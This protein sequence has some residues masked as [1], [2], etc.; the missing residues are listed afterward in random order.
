MS[1]VLIPK[2]TIDILRRLA[3]NV[4]R[5][6][7]L[8]I[9]A[10]E[11]KMWCTSGTLIGDIGSN[12]LPAHMAIINEV[13]QLNLGKN[14]AVVI[15]RC[16]E[17]NHELSNKQIHDLKEKSASGPR[18]HQHYHAW[19]VLDVKVEQSDIIDITGHHF[20]G[21]DVSEN[22]MNNQIAAREKIKHHAVLTDIESVYSYHANLVKAQLTAGTTQEKRKGLIAYLQ[23][24]AMLQG[25]SEEIALGEVGR[26]ALEQEN[27]ISTSDSQKTSTVKEKLSSYF[28]SNRSNSK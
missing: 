9:E 3:Q 11:P 24:F 19:I 2:A 10:D 8:R 6:K 21:K 13:K 4:I 5:N 27:E 23:K 16:L 12:C 25:V 20:M 15:G 14:P 26:E 22:Y 18:P 7:Y 17:Q 1:S 28:R